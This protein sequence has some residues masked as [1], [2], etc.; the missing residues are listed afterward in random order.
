[1]LGLWLTALALIVTR[2]V[3]REVRR[4]RSV[5]SGDRTP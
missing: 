3:R 4:R 2:E 5:G 1:V